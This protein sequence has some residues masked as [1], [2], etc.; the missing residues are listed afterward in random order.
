MATSAENK[1]SSRALSAAGNIDLPLQMQ[2]SKPVVARGVLD[3]SPYLMKYNSKGYSTKEERSAN[4]TSNG[5][6]A[7]AVDRHTLDSKLTFHQQ[8]S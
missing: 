3:Q 8:S 2:T 5:E 1:E 7:M 4:T 6:E